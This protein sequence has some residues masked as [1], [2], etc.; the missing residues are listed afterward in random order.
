PDDTGTA[1]TTVSQGPDLAL[2]KST[3]TRTVSKSGDVISYTIDVTNSD[4]I[5]LASANV[6]VTD[7][8]ADA[9]SLMLVGGNT[10]DTGHLNVGERSEER[11]VGKESKAQMKAGGTMNNT[12]IVSDSTDGVTAEPEDNANARK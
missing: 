10:N 8:F 5:D 2:S 7:P 9:N 3:S 11:R 6:V 12:T 1:T 4:N